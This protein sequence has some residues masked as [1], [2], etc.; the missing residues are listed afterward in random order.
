MVT[1]RTSSTIHRDSIHWINSH[2][3]AQRR[4]PA[5]SHRFFETSQAVGLATDSSNNKS[6]SY[7]ATC[8][9]ALFDVPRRF[10]G[11]NPPVTK[12]STRVPPCHGVIF[13]PRKG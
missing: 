5:A 1:D 13:D 10:S 11:M 6:R 9:M 7:S 4:V 2:E 12:A 3:V 8:M